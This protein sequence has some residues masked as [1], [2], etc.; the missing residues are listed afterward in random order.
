MVCRISN[1]VA[2]ALCFLLTEYAMGILWHEPPRGALLSQRWEPAAALP[3]CKQLYTSWGLKSPAVSGVI[4]RVKAYQVDFL[5][6]L[7]HKTRQETAPRSL[8][9]PSCSQ[10]AASSHVALRNCWVAAP[11]IWMAQGSVMSYELKLSLFQT[12]FLDGQKK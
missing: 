6:V 8:D 12:I 10:L 2:F 1:Q 4:T 3:V 5:F 11:E 7:L 9:G